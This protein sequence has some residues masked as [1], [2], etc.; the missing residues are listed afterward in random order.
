MYD[1]LLLTLFLVN[2]PYPERTICAGRNKKIPIG[3]M[4][5]RCCNL[6]DVSLRIVHISQVHVAFVEFRQSFTIS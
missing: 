6:G 4:P 5:G 1:H 2:V 3:R